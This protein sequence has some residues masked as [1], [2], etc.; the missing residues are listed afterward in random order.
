MAGCRKPNDGKH[1]SASYKIFGVFCF[2]GDALISPSAWE[3]VNFIHEGKGFQRPSG[4]R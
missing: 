2:L 4:K 1:S 3:A